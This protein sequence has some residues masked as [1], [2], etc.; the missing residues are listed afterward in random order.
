MIRNRHLAMILAFKMPQHEASTYHDHEEFARF[1]L[2][3]L[4]DTEYQKFNVATDHSGF[5]FRDMRPWNDHELIQ[6][7]RQHTEAA[8]LLKELDALH[9]EDPSLE[10]DVD[11]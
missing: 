4:T 11:G 1:Y 5:G 7:A 9:E 6:K 10:D 3:L 8:K 2:G